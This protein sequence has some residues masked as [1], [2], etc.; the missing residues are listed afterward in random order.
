MKVGGGG[1]KFEGVCSD[2]SSVDL[3]T[4]GVVSVVGVADGGCPPGLD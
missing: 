3:E 2:A 4:Y 1:F